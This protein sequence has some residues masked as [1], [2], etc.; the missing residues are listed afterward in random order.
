MTSSV[1]LSG[2]GVVLANNIADSIAASAPRALGIASAYLTLEG[3]E[4]IADI[5]RKNK[6]ERVA[7][8]AGVSGAVTHP[9]ALTYLSDASI[10]VRMGLH[11]TGIFHP[12][13]FVG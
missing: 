6:I 13:M 1:V 9:L 2:T 3:A 5:K 12:K 4:Y 8:I 11:G 7:V 10:D